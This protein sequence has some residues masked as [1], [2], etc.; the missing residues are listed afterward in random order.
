MQPNTWKYFPFPE[1]SIS[2]KYV[3]SGKRFTA[4]KHSLSNFLFSN[5][6][7]NPRV[8]RKLQFV[9]TVCILDY[10][11]DNTLFFLMNSLIIMS[12]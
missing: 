11:I 2:E 4:T 1:I 3:F 5:S 8:P 12:K 9:S 6:N 10:V 7:L